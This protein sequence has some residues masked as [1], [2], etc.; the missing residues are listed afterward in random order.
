M[1]KRIGY[2]PVGGIREAGFIECSDYLMVL[3]SQGRTIFNCLNNEK[4]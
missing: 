1:W 4:S 2:Q 3:G